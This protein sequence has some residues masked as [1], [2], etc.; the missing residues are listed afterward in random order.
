MD[1]TRVAEGVPPAPLR[2]FEA[3]A[4]GQGGLVNG[5]EIR[6]S[7][8]GLNPQ[9]GIEAQPLKGAAFL[10]RVALHLLE[11][12]AVIEGEDPHGRPVPLAVGG[13]VHLLE[14]RVVA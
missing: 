4:N 7:G 8:P 12:R 5:D 10:E 14:L 1:G 2:F 11:L 3:V 13:P 9:R 6:T